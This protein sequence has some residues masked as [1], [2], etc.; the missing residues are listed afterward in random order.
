MARAKFNA[1]TF[2]TQEQEL[3]KVVL[4]NVTFGLEQP[5]QMAKIGSTNKRQPKVSL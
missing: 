5:K 4:A 1:T 2:A 3:A